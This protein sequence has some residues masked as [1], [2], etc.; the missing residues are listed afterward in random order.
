MSGTAINSTAVSIMKC[1]V[2]LFKW[3]KDDFRILDRK[4]RKLLTIYRVFH[5]QGN[6]DRLHVKRSKG[7][8]VLSGEYCVNMEIANLKV[9][10]TLIFF[11]IFLTFRLNGYSVWSIVLKKKSTRFSGALIFCRASWVLITYIVKEVKNVIPF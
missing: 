3:T 6:V 10:M 8:R 11:L 9:P 5:P 2:V 4:T 1:G 7:G